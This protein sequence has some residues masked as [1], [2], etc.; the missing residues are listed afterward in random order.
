[1]LKV[2]FFA[3]TI[4]YLWLLSDLIGGVAKQEDG[5]CRHVAWAAYFLYFLSSGKLPLQSEKVPLS[6]MHG[7]GAL[8]FV[9]SWVLPFQMENTN[10][11][12]K[13]HTKLF[14]FYPS[15]EKARKTKQKALSPLLCTVISAKGVRS[16]PGLHSPD[17][18][19]GRDSSEIHQLSP[20]SVTGCSSPKP[21]SHTASHTSRETR[22][23]CS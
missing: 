2:E 13:T 14:W 15:I 17:T 21:Q 7:F 16:P 8:N 12:S 19:S 4:S 18:S 10:H 22:C 5:R 1:M 20:C 9:A 6:K 23:D 3:V 11:Y